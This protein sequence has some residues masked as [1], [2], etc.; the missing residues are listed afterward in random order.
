MQTVSLL[1]K[2][3]FAVSQGTF[4][5]IAG[6]TQPTVSRWERDG[7]YC[8]T[9]AQMLRIRDEAERRGIEWDDRWFF[10]DPAAREAAE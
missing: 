8:M 9:L 5:A 2:N 6:V 4:A 10:F 7:A 1:R 3:I